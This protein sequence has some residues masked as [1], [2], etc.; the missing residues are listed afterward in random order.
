MQTNCVESRSLC[1]RGV[2]ISISARDTCRTWNVGEIDDSRPSLFLCPQRRHWLH[3]SL[4]WFLAP[5]LRVY[6]PDPILLRFPSPRPLQGPGTHPFLAAPVPHAGPKSVCPSLP[7]QPLPLTPP[8]PTQPP[9]FAQLPAALPSRSGPGPIVQTLL[10]Q[11][12]QSRVAHDRVKGL[13]GSW[14]SLIT[15]AL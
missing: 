4:D 12:L 15:G 7:T 10:S 5:P 11:G 8:R 1:V 2:K 6:A 9:S 14:T 13:L 3:P